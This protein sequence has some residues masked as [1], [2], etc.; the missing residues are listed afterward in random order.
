MGVPRARARPRCPNALRVLSWLP[1]PSSPTWHTSV[2]DTE[3]PLPAAACP[4]LTPL[5][6]LPGTERLLQVSPGP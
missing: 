5:T 2:G 3:G 4:P 6:G 1:V